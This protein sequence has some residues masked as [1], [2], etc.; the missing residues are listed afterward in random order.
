MQITEYDHHLAEI[1]TNPPYS[2]FDMVTMLAQGSFVIEGK[3]SNVSDA[4]YYAQRH[5]EKAE[6]W[7]ALRAFTNY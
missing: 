4:E 7:E 2:H 1:V 6:V 5:S 3:Q